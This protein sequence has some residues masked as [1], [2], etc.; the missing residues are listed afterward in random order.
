MFSRARLAG[1]ASAV[2]TDGRPARCSRRQR[3]RD[4]TGARGFAI[5]AGFLARV[6][7]GQPPGKAAWPAKPPAASSGLGSS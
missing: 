6:A 4:G 2:D 7:R 5:G 3:R 1:A